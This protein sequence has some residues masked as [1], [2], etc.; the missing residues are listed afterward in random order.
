M[1]FSFQCMVFVDHFL[2]L[3]S[4]FLAIVLSVLLRFTDFDY[5]FNIFKFFLGFGL[6]CLKPL[7][8]I[9]QLYRGGQFYWWRKPEYTWKTTD[10]PQVNDIHNVIS[11]THRLS[12][13]LTRIISGDKRFAQI[14]VNPTTIR[15]R[16]RQS[17]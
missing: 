12:G 17:F 7:S 13:I 11:S 1:I 9:F 15:S 16:P 3:C 2:Y 8:T 10:L 5:P 14:V 4:F 6:W